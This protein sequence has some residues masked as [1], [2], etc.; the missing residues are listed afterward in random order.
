MAEFDLKSPH[1]SCLYYLYTYKSLTAKELCDLCDEDKASISRSLDYLEKNEY[2]VCN[3]A[4]KKRYKSP[5]ELTSK[6]EAIGQKIVAIIDDMLD[7]ASV[8]MTDE[9]RV[10]LYKTLGLVS[11]NLQNI[12]DNYE[13]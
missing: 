13:E 4:L 3:T 5:L 6:G 12:C 10:I 9:E 11:D 2:I 7:R 1:V 8:G